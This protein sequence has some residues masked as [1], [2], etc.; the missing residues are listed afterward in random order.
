MR[1]EQLLAE[2]ERLLQ[3]VMTKQENTDG[4]LRFGQTCVSAS[5]IAQQY[6]CE[7]KVEMQY[8]HGKVETE[9]KQLG[10]EGHETLLIDTVKVKRAEL[11]E[12]I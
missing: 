9:A 8:L 11:L 1:L 5:C 7:K 4:V 10:T 6:F 3:A 12:Q 2:Q